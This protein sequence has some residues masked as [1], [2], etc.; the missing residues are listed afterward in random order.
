MAKTPHAANNLLKVLRHLLECAVDLNL[1]DVNPALGVK[2][3]KIAGD[4]IHTWT[5]DEVAQFEACT[6]GTL[7]LSRVA[8]LLD[9]GQRRSDVVRMGW[10]H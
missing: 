7:A 6:G 3:F 4:G 8:L 1:I 9:T 10:Q 5:E 2:K